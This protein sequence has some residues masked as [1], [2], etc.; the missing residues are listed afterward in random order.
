M[1]QQG[2]DLQIKPVWAADQGDGNYQNPILFAD[3]S[4]PDVIRVGDDFFMVASSFNCMP[5]IP[6]L[7][8][9]DLVNWQIVNHV[10]ERF[11]YPD[12]EKPAHGRAAWAPSI[13]YH[14]NKYWVFFSAPDEG[15]FISSTEDPFGHWS[16]L[17]LVK[18]VKGWID[19]CPFW[20]EDGNAYL[21]T[22]FAFSRSGIKHKLQ[23]F[24]MKPDGTGLL[25]DGVIIFDG[26]DHHPTVEGPK[27]YKRNGY[28]YIFA[29][30]GG[31]RIGWQLILR[32]KNIYGPYE[33]KIVLHQGN[34]AINGPHQGGF[35]ELE[36][37]ESW[38]IH[39]QDRAAYGRI[40]HLQP[41][42]W[43][44][45][46]PLMGVDQNGDGIGEPVL[47][48]KKPNVGR[49][50]PICAPDTTDDFNSQNLGLQWQWQANPN[51]SWYS[52]T[53][54]P[55]HIRLF[56]V[57]TNE[58]AHTLF[59]IPNLLLQKLP[60]PAFIATAK[61]TF[62]PASIGDLAG[63][64]IMGS[65]YSYL[66]LCLTD[67]G[68]RISQVF[69]KEV[70]KTRKEIVV[71]G[72]SIEAQTLYLRVKV[73]EPACCSF[74]F[75]LDGVNFSPLGQSFAAQEGRWIGAKVG[76]FSTNLTTG[77][78]AGFTDFDWF[79]VTSIASKGE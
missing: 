30:A 23:L 3:Y 58:E 18:Q 34:T 25:D 60:A 72:Q 55:G 66:A 32:S 14:D 54:R 70:D 20:D 21:V 17:V 78:E 2:S 63:I 67:Q 79:L 9:K 40:V 6:V 24:K 51:R 28:Y 59:E 42:T 50:Y 49:D 75:S 71:T 26:T 48:C 41:V 16:P 11:P 76:I 12:Y 43:E 1:H 13:R 64:V 73:V 22:A 45:D 19:P 33:G 4:D 77:S 52:L 15:I 47:F 69:G 68:L 44:N 56:S 65:E 39:F 5:G 53:D 10:Y 35:V 62:Q 27:M 61:M 57:N 46:W 74:Y 36:S 38:F 8:S 29:P 31:V 7:H 37:G